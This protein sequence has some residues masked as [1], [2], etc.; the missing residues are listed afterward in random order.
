MV[1]DRPATYQ[2]SPNFSGIN[3]FFILGKQPD[4]EEMASCPRAQG[5]QLP[6][7]GPKVQ[8][9]PSFLILRDH[10]VNECR[11]RKTFCR[12]LR[13]RKVARPDISS[14][15]HRANRLN[16]SLVF[17]GELRRFSSR[18]AKNFPYLFNNRSIRF[19]N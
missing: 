14:F 12:L 1:G 15:K 3:N 18:D 13:S 7:L 4:G 6:T 19:K 5:W 11:S 9:R 8:W 17:K 16:L 2:A 10:V